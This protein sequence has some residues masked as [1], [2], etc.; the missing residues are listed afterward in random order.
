VR[1]N[2]RVAGG[3]ALIALALIPLTPPGV[4]VLAAAAAVLLAGR[5]R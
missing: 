2:L 4:P 5:L 1:V 3:A